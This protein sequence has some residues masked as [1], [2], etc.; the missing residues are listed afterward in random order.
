MYMGGKNFTLAGLAVDGAITDVADIAYLYRPARHHADASHSGSTRLG[1]V[2]DDA[3]CRQ[4]H[5][6][7]EDVVFANREFGNGIGGIAADNPVDHDKWRTLRNQLGDGNILE[8]HGSHFILPLTGY[9]RRTGK[10]S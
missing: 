2:L 4:K 7:E 9:S 5:V 1:H 6:V 8:L 10:A 3:G